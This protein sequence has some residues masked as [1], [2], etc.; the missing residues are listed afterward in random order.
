MV[1]SV[2]IDDFDLMRPVR[3]PDETETPLIIDA[4]GV[5]ALPVALE[6]FQAVAGWDGEVIEF[7]DGLKLGEFP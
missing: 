5:L 6:S 2:V 4:D 1:D 3:F 7:G